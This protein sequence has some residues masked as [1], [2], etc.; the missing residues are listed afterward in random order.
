[1]QKVL[2]CIPS[3]RVLRAPCAR[4]QIGLDIRILTWTY[5]PFDELKVIIV[6]NGHGALTYGV[7]GIVLLRWLS[8]SR[9][10]DRVQAD[11]PPQCSAKPRLMGPDTNVK[12]DFFLIPAQRDDLLLD[13]LGLR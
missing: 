13:Y 7:L 2:Y 4:F 3:E 12:G 8:T 10:N 5:R 1:M 9:E 6:G 11:E